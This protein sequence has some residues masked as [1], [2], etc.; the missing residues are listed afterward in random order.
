MR[1]KYILVVMPYYSCNEY[2]YV[3]HLLKKLVTMLNIKFTME[4]KQYFAF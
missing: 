3:N 2:H 4:E 1:V